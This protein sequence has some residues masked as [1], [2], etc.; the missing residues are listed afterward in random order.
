MAKCDIIL[1][2]D[3]R[4][5]GIMI[6]NHIRTITVIVAVLLILASIF[7]Y[8][9]KFINVIDK[10]ELYKNNSYNVTCTIDEFPFEKDNRIRIYGHIKN[11]DHPANITGYKV[12]FDIPKDNYDILKYGNT[13]R[14]TAKIEPAH[15][16]SNYGNFN[17]RDYLMS[18]NTVAISELDNNT[19]V[20]LISQNKGI[21]MALY[22][23]QKT[24]IFNTEKYFSGDNGALIKAMLTGDREDI[25]DDL[26]ES[27]QKSGIY[28]IVSVSGLHTGIFVSV[29]TYFL[30][31]L[32]FGTR[33]K[34]LISKITAIILSTLLLMFTGYGVSVTRVILM[35]AVTAVCFMS[36]REYNIIVSILI[37][38]FIIVL[39]A[40]YNIFNQSFQLSF[41]STLGLCIALKLREKYKMSNRFEYIKSSLAI[42]AGSSAATAPI[43]AY[44]FGTVSIAGFIANIIIIPLATVL[45]ISIIVFCTLSALLPSPVMYILA[46]IPNMLAEVINTIAEIVSKFK[47]SSI[48]TNLADVFS[49]FILSGI[50]FM[51]INLI[52]RK[53]YFNSALLLLIVLF[54][55]FSS[56]DLTTN[57]MRVTFINCVK[58]ESTIITTPSN[59]TIMFDCGSSSFSDPSE[60]LF[61]TYFNHNEIT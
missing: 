37:A 51:T 7:S 3:K 49:A 17:Y 34:S 24:T 5:T 27:Y 14:F 36:H 33:R 53:K 18:K 47:Y 11:S 32:P 60:D 50:I 9:Y 1:S 25:D 29:F 38:A 13:I 31:F 16:G 46:Y 59:K 58:G 56:A 61:E 52:I 35:S 2:T 28:H 44:C 55:A 42:S 39:F 6:K 23:M 4:T 22:N 41:V 26:R 20:E 45:L 54:M 57:K 10:L 48:E 8:I 21:S 19:H 43:S 30:A 12:L 40:P 15:S